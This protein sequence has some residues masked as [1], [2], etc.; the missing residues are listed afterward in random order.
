MALKREQFLV[1]Q[2]RRAPSA[3]KSKIKS[4][5]GALTPGGRANAGSSSIKPRAKSGGR[6]KSTKM[7]VYTMDTPL[8]T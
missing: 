7:N 5:L 4:T 8:P 1:N 6:V 2:P 3:S